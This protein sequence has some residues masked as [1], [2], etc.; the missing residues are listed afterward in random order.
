[1]KNKIKEY[2]YRIKEDKISNFLNLMH[3]NVSG[4]GIRVFSE[5]TKLNKITLNQNRI[6]YIK[7]GSTNIFV[8]NVEF[9]LSVGD[10]LFTRAYS[11][12]EATTFEGECEIYYIYFDILPHHLEKIFLE[13]IFFSKNLFTFKKDANLL[14][15]LF[16]EIISNADEQRDSSYYISQSYF[17]ILIA[18]IYQNE[19]KNNKDKEVT[20]FFNNDKEKYLNLATEYIQKHIE[21]NIKLEDI[22]KEI[23]ITSNY[24]YKIFIELLKVSPKEYILERRLELVAKLLVSTNLS[25]NEIA[26]NLDFSS[27]AHLTKLFKQFYNIAPNKYRKDLMN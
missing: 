2:M 27:Q 24:I 11:V 22:A 10:M 21:Q 20:K 19:V 6:I 25:I 3:F 4:C 12:L 26:F 17:S 23:G 16:S 15:M 18:L 13:D 14:N 9:E 8:N 1:M 5:K 7:K